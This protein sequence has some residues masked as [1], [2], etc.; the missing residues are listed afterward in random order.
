MKVSRLVS[1]TAAVVVPAALVLGATGA[2]FAAKPPRTPVPTMTS[3]PAKASSSRSATFG[4]D[5]VA[6]TAYTCS[7]D[8]STYSTCASPKTYSNL[9]NRAHTFVLKAK[10]TT[11]ANSKASSYSY[12][13]TVDTVAPAAPV[14]TP[15][16]GPTSNTNASVSFSESDASVTGFTCALDS[17]TATAC[18]SPHPYSG[19]SD[20]LHTVVVTAHDAAG[21]SSFGS[22]SWTVDTL[23]PNIPVLS[24]PASI[25]NNPDATVSFVGDGETYTCA[26]DGET[27]A[28]C[29]SPWAHTGLADGS[30]TLTVTPYDLVPNAGTPGAVTWFVDTVAP[31]A[32]SLVTAPAAHTQSTDAEVVFADLL[33]D[34]VSHVCTL[35]GIAT[36]CSSPFD[37]TALALGGHT[38]SVT[39][40]DA[41]GNT[42]TALSL[43]WTV[44]AVSGPA[45]FVSGPTSPSNSTHPTFDWVA[46]DTATNAFQCQLDPTGAW[47]A[48]NPGDGFDVGAGQRVLSVE[49]S[50]DNGAT[51]SDPVVWSWL[52]DLTGPTQA[53]NNAAGPLTFT[54]PVNSTPTFTFTNP[55]PSTI[56][57]FVCSVDGGPWTP[58]ASGYVPVVGDG[59]H[60]LQVAT[61]DQAG[62]VGAPI[63]YSWTLD[64]TAP[65]GVIAF[66]TTLAGAVKVSFAEPVLGVTTSTAR[67]LLAGT[68]TPAVT[69]LGCLGASGSTVSCGSASVRS[70]LLTPQPRLVP[71]QK[72][73]LAVT[74][75]VHDAAGNAAVV[76]TT[77]YR[78]QRLLQETEPVIGQSW[79]SKVA[80]AAYGGR[81]SQAR[82]SGAQVMYPFRG[83]SITWYTATGPA[84]GTAKV[85]CGNTLKATVNN[86]SASARWYVA[87]TVTCSSS[88]ANNTLRVLATGLKGSTAGKGTQVV[89]DAVKL[90][91]TLTTNPV[92]T[93]RWGT[94]PSSLASG[95]RYAG[96]DQSSGFSLTF[97]GTSITWR[98]LLGKNMGIAKVY[99][100]GI[101]KGTYDQF[102]TTTKSYSRTWKLTDK[103]HTIKVV[104]TGTHRTGATGTQV[105]LDALTVG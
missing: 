98:T 38:F 52:V 40:S 85:Y 95:G 35:D 55:D 48:C 80:T 15:V 76:A 92:I 51:W 54:D 59:T 69:K 4:W 94:V 71:G 83:T 16:A 47:T 1:R 96:N 3:T 13:W 88:T 104:V 87:R 39:S 22:T 33:L 14:V 60:Q 25:T 34:V 24:G 90:G 53:P 72:Y 46:T 73:R 37:A 82:L 81:Y 77:V 89:F 75:A 19:L 36:P 10:L 43:G 28:L 27:A 99:V 101:Y 31:A 6:N 11:Q 70:V 74:S 56:A 8:G 68:T 61:V 2:A 5:V 102:A 32:P 26:L 91:A 84:M 30:H 67:L 44:D 100:D 93:Q 42:S 65:H 58:C 50:S 63:T 29:T 23:A 45:A 86:Y 41:A 18:T 103:V 64:E 97:R 20:T 7:L 17:G 62:N 66:P 12:S 57:G 21:N 79:T 78:A 105:V 49:A 9:A